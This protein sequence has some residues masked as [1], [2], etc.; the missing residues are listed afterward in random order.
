M[1]FTAIAFD[2]ETFDFVEGITFASDDDKREGS[3][4]KSDLLYGQCQ[5]CYILSLSIAEG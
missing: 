3:N 5:W 2:D 4:A 1:V